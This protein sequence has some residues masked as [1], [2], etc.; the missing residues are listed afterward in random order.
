MNIAIILSGG[1]GTRL[2]ADTPKQYI[3]IGGK[4]LITYCLETLTGHP[5]IDALQ[6]VAAPE[7]EADILADAE[8]N[9]LDIGKIH[10]FSLPGQ[11]RQSS[12][13]SA[14]T[15]IAQDSELLA[16]TVLIHDAARPNLSA[17]MISRCME[18]IKGHEGVMPVLPMKDTI[19]VSE[20]GRKVSE[21]VDRSRV[22]AG[23]APEL[24]CFTKYME[25]NRVLLPDKIGQIKGSTEPAVMA[26]MDIVM[27]PGDER[28]FKVTT[29]DDLER[30]KSS[31]EG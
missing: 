18:A 16:D 3:R 2:G 8:N 15:D 10:G 5:D 31:M 29:Q 14:L 6:I 9:G 21:L 7:W 25:A 28:N 22:F 24:F 13:W 27:I 11:E 17:E 30:F 19:Y 1:T 12:I 4:L 26:G 23:Q 20:D